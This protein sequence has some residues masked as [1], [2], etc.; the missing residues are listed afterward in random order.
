MCPSRFAVNVIQGLI[1]TS[2][3]YVGVAKNDSATFVDIDTAD[4]GREPLVHAR[5][6]LAEHLSCDRIEVWREDDRIA[7]IDRASQ[8]HAS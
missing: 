3:V 8:A 4:S 1:M 2:Y 7:V 5:G 6:L